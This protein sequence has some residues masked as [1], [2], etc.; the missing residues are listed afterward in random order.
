M[1]HHSI[2][3]DSYK[4]YEIKTFVVCIK[5]QQQQNQCLQ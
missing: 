5:R 1:K 2:D 4:K 3:K